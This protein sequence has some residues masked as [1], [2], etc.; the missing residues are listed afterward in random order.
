MFSFITEVIGGSCDK[1]V[2]TE[3]ESLRREMLSDRRMVK[4][5]DLGAGSARMKGELRTVRR[6]ASAAAVPAREAALLARIANSFDEG[7]LRGIAFGRQAESAMGGNSDGLIHREGQKAGQDARTG[8]G[9]LNPGS[10]DTTEEY[11]GSRSPVSSVGKQGEIL[12]PSEHDQMTLKDV[13]SG[14]DRTDS[15]PVPGA[16]TAVRENNPGH[17]PVI[18]ELGTS[19]GLSALALALGAPHRRVITVEGSPELALIARENLRRH[20][21]V[22]A[23]VIYG[24]F[25]E[26]LTKLRNSG[27]RVG[28]A[29]VDGNHRGSALVEYVRL[30]REMGEEVI[31]VADDI[32]MNSEMI[33]AWRS[34]T[35]ESDIHRSRKKWSA[36]RKESERSAVVMQASGVSYDLTREQTLTSQPGGVSSASQKSAGSSAG[37]GATESASVRP[38]AGSAG[39]VPAAD[40]GSGQPLAGQ[41]AGTERDYGRGIIMAPAS[42]ETFRMGILFFLHN[43]TP[44]HYR[45][46]Y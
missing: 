27:T 22:N 4:V 1:A 10:H 40:T 3:V 2:V 44:G 32:R 18:L 5:T 16:S 19:L 9:N 12:P 38:A 46:L 20:G 35:K 24:E 15:H 41:E 33:N 28:L 45:V 39:A 29:F 26:V 36:S 37:P 21:G 11:H 13:F 7:G 25:R 31:I 8:A 23:E 14:Q 30:I 34:L 6:I 42:L 17:V 43:L